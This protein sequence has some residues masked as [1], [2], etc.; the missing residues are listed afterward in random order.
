MGSKLKR[1]ARIFP[2]KSPEKVVVTMSGSQSRFAG[3]IV[4]LAIETVMMLPKAKTEILTCSVPS[5]TDN[6]CLF[7]G[8]MH[9]N[10]LWVELFFRMSRRKC[11]AS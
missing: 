3:G 7:L 11:Q 5:F 4:S 1:A 2:T 6:T 10:I 9:R 8:K